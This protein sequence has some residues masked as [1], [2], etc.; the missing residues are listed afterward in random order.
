[1]HR[2]NKGMQVGDYINYVV[3]AILS[4]LCIS[5]FLYVLSVSFT[6]PDVYVPLE[7]ILIPSKFSLAA[8]EYVLSSQNFLSALS[9]SV[10]VTVIG[11]VL[12]L[13]V[14]FSLAYPLSKNYIPGV[15]A[16]NGLV[17]FTLIF[18]AGIVP[19]YILVKDLGLIDN[20]AALILPSLTSAW[21][22][23]VVRSFMRSLPVE[24][25]E[26]ARID[27]CSDIVVFIRIVIPLSM[28]SI[29]AF[30]LFFAV[31]NWNAYFAPMIYIS[32]TRKWTLQ[33]LLKSMIIDSEA[34]GYG[35]SQEVDQRLPPQETIKMAII[36]MTM[37]PILVVY[38]FLQKYF[39]KGV[40]LGSVKG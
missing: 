7:L 9:N 17:V 32:D 5:P 21:N 3:L 36:V 18:N 25:E 19:T 14:T 40:M 26:A 23:V 39:A 33:V 29:A 4:L 27:G 24:V 8:Y 30:T 38:P 34:I 15:K 2:L 31:A 12:N 1:M 22:L 13:I 11:T 37:L 6:D 10:L 28:A 16:M 20:L 35:F